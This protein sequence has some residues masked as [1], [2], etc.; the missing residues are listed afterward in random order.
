VKITRPAQDAAA[1]TADGV[2]VV[3]RH[4]ARRLKVEIASSLARNEPA[5]RSLPPE[6]WNSPSPVLKFT[7]SVKTPSPGWMGG[8]TMKP[9]GTTTAMPDAGGPRADSALLEASST[10]GDGMSRQR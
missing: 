1:A 8:S 2:Q 5:C 10:P 7:S 6:N 9:S 4:F 3:R